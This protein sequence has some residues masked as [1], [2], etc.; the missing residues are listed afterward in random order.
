MS[1]RSTLKSIPYKRGRPVIKP[2]RP[3]I[4]IACW[5]GL[6]DRDCGDLDPVDAVELL[7]DQSLERDV[8][9]RRRTVGG[10]GQERGRGNVVQVR[11]LVQQVLP[12]EIVSAGLDD[13]SHD[14]GERI[15]G[16]ADL[17]L[18]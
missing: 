13:L 11:G 5:P 8:I 14:V 7:H 1:P 4:P 15:D 2:G 6:I 16:K 9:V 18:G 10:P 12:R 17:V 3:M